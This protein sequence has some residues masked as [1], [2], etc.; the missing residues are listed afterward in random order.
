MKLLFL[1]LLVSCGKNDFLNMQG[2]PKK[3]NTDKTFLDYVKNFESINGKIK[4]SIIFGDLKSP[5]VGV[6]KKWNNSSYREVEIDRNFWNNSSDEKREQLIL[7]ELGHCELNLNREDSFLDDNCPAS[8]M[9]SYVFFDHEINN[10]F[11]PN[12]KY[13]L[14]E[15]FL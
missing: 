11:V 14:D 10:C 1:L 9:R 7:H 3:H 8:V 4:S 5:Q 12:F 15:L 13:Y 2:E 6:C